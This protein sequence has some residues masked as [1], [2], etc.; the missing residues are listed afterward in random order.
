MGYLEIGLKGSGGKMLTVK[1][2]ADGAER[3]YE[4]FGIVDYRKETK[5]ILFHE[6]SSDVPVLIKTGKIYVMNEAGST[7][8]TYYLS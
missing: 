7:I 1:H 4:V 2:Q 6:S 5:E 8:G 3:L